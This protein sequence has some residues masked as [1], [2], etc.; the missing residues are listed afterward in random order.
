MVTFAYVQGLRGP[1]PQ[2]WEDKPTN[3]AGVSKSSL[4]S[5]EL[6]DTYAALPL[7]QLVMLYPYKGG[8]DVT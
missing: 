5:V 1:E 7:E 3:G 6:P 2:R 4:Q 8:F